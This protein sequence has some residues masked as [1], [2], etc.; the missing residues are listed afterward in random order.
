MTS[1]EKRA[2]R[3][4]LEMDDLAGRL[5]NEINLLQAL[6][7]ALGAEGLSADAF[8]DGLFALTGHLTQLNKELNWMMA[9][10]KKR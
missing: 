8:T 6:C 1:E 10:E 5:S 2:R 3:W 9:R 7:A 4:I